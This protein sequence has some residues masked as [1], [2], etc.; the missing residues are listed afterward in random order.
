[1][2]DFIVYQTFI[3]Q[4]EAS[5]L[6]DLLKENTIDYKVE[7]SS[8]AFNPSFVFTPEISVLISP[9]NVRLVDSLFVSQ[10][11]SDHYLFS[12]SE[13][14][15][16]GIIEKK[17]E[18][19]SFDY[20]LAQKILSD[21]GILLDENTMKEIENQRIE[22]LRQ[23]EE[24][25]KSWIIIGYA[26]ILIGALP[27]IFI[28]YSIWKGTKTLPNGEKIHRFSES[29]RQHGKWITWISTALFIPFFI[30][31]FMENIQQ[32]MN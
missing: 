14:E 21:K 12:F 22:E 11:P 8:G 29:D 15:L 32:Q 13:A 7:S 27:G 9:L 4:E 2:E 17:D 10:A 5:D 6:V 24:S 31:R 19:S 26:L 20:Q 30:W 3:N 16:R 1:M 25:Q 23:P 18:W 28:G